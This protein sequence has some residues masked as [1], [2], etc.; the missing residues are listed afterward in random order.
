MQPPSRR[1]DQRPGVLALPPGR[2]HHGSGGAPERLNGLASA[3]APEAFDALVRASY[4]W[5]AVRPPLAL[6]I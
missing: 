5:T 3:S 4:I 2:A 1:I 6:G